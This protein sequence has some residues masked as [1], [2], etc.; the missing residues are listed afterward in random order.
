MDQDFVRRSIKAIGQVV[1]KV[2]RVA[3]KGIE[4]LREYINHEAGT[5]SALQEAVIASSKILRKYP[6]KHDHL[7]KDICAQVERIDEPESKAAL[8]WILGEFADKIDN[9]DKILQ[10]YIDSFSDEPN[11]VC[12][13]ILT[14]AVKMYIKKSD[15]CEDMVM[16]VLKLASEESDNP[17]LRDRGYIYWRMLSTD[18]TATKDV[19]LIKR[20]EYT[21]ELSNLMG[22]EVKEIFEHTVGIEKKKVD[23]KTKEVPEENDDEEE[24]DEKEVVEEPKKSKKGKKDK[25]AKADKKQKKNKKEKEKVQQVE[26]EEEVV[27]DEPPASSAL[28]DILG[29]GL[30]D[31]PAP[32]S[33]VAPGSAVSDPLADIFGP[34]PT[35]NGASSGMTSATPAWDS[36]DIF[37]GS[38]GAAAS[39]VS[40]ASTFVKPKWAEVLSAGTAG[41]SGSS[42]LKIN[43]RFYRDG[44][45]IKLELQITNTTPSMVSDFEIMF[46]K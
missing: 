9:S 21:E 46:N 15:E 30:S 37:G 13:Q 17:D 2:D 43:G 6:K 5:E 32:S 39:P 26:V 3:K 33:S 25:G 29:L 7:I 34:P 40:D 10:G 35:S 24:E 27:V 20:P 38:L 22:N 11:H 12:L 31:E 16:N 23:L 42:G 45:Q 41:Q 8:I 28:D 14:A 18:P 4:S 19:I 36:S 1:C 44:A